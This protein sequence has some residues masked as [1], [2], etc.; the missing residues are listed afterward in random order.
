[1]VVLYHVEILFVT[2]HVETLMVDEIIMVE[3]MT[4][5]VHHDEMTHLEMIMEMAVNHE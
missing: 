5:E 3:I 1:M 2:D 4:D